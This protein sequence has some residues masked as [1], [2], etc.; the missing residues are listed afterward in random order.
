MKRTAALALAC[1]FEL[2]S[3]GVDA[4]PTLVDH[5]AIRFFS[6]ETGGPRKPRFLTE[7]TL[8]FLARLEALF[9]NANATSFQERHVRAALEH[10][11]AAVML[12]ELPLE[13]APTS[14]DLLDAEVHF[15]RGVLERVGGEA[16][17]REALRAEG[18]SLAE[19]QMLLRPK[20]RSALYI[21]RTQGG[22]FSPTSEE[23]SEIYR[24]SPHPFG[25][26]PLEE[27]RAS[28]TRWVT[29]ER[30]RLFEESFFQ[31]ART[32]VRIVTSTRPW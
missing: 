15:V 22:I 9:E 12:S 29:I 31:A 30:T 18:L 27:V 8:S 1:A 11:I 23:L 16:R 14:G 7:R 28:L 25:S 32:R 2:F 6:A 10:A 19:V 13:R 20:V 3:P 5:V 4:A 17:F 26:R 24:T 21:D